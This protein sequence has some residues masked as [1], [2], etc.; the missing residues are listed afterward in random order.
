MH[1]FFFK[2][3]PLTLSLNLFVFLLGHYLLQQD[4]QYAQGEKYQK[5]HDKF[6]GSAH[7][8]FSCIGIDER[9]RKLSQP[10]GPEK[11][12]EAHGREPCGITDYI[13]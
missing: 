8:H 12:P 6:L 7:K 2:M 4:G 5:A 13:K 10:G 1:V 11:G 3:P 9:G